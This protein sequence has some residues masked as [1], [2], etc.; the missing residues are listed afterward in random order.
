MRRPPR[1]A[2]LFIGY[3]RERCLHPDAASLLPDLATARAVQHTTL[4]RPALRGGPP[5]LASIRCG[6][7]FASWRDQP[8]AP[9]SGCVSSTR[10]ITATTATL[11]QNRPPLHTLG[12]DRL[13]LRIHAPIH[14]RKNAN[15]AVDRKTVDPAPTQIGQPG[16]INSQCRGRDVKV[17]LTRDSDNRIR[18]LPLQRGNGV[19]EHGALYPRHRDRASSQ[20]CR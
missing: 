11:S 10:R 18:Q 2:S 16:R 7:L 12:A 5:R 15:Q 8:V 3:A 9:E 20:H 6:V 19:I 13:Y 17:R 14:Y 1:A 4:G